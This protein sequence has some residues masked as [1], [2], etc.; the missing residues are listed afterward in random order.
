MHI[1]FLYYLLSAYLNV[2]AVKETRANDNVIYDLYYNV[3]Y[4]FSLYPILY[5]TENDN[6]L[7]LGYA[8]GLELI[9]YFKNKGIEKEY[10]VELMSMNFYQKKY[11]IVDENF[12]SI[13]NNSVPYNYCYE[14]NKIDNNYLNDFILPKTEKGNLNISDIEN[15]SCVLYRCLSNNIIL[16]NLH[17]T[18]GAI[19]G[20]YRN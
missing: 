12:L 2:F 7:M 10:F 16:V 11:F 5:K 4:E 20:R 15:F 19:L 17:G 9:P 6:S 1:L 18:D 13:I 14:F 3:N 8:Y